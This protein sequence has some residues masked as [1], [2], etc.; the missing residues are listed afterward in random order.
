VLSS[1]RHFGPAAFRSIAEEL[2][3][4]LNALLVYRGVVHED[5]DVEGECMALDSVSRA[6]GKRQELLPRAIA[7]FGDKESP[8]FCDSEFGKALLQE[9]I[10][11]LRAFSELICRLKPVAVPVWDSSDP[12][13]C[14]EYPVGVSFDA[15]IDGVYAST[16][17]RGFR[18]RRKSLTELMQAV[19]EVSS[20]DAGIREVVADSQS[21][22][23]GTECLDDPMELCRADTDGEAVVQK[24]LEDSKHLI[25]RALSVLC[26]SEAG[27]SDTDMARLFKDLQDTG[28]AVSVEF[29][30]YDDLRNALRELAVCFEHECYSAVMGLAGKILEICLK[31]RLDD[32]GIAYGDDM[33]LGA[34]LTKLKKSKSD[35]DYIDPNLNNIANIINQSRIPAVHAKEKIPVPSREQAAM[36]VFAAA[37]M[38]KRTFHQEST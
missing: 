3:E 24:A 9:I 26:K 5:E 12:P 10:P 19:S 8:L 21:A 4:C 36:V 33:M 35:A 17:S 1:R 18:R 22:L 11:R 25:S 27:G 6:W 15:A 23:A 20:I 13:W 32:M 16:E 31:Q 38:L 7:F 14:Q 34:L 37:D 2:V 29:V 30:Y 28:A